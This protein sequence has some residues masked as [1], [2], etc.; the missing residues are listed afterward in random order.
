MKKLRFPDQSASFLHFFTSLGRLQIFL[1]PLSSR[2]RSSP[3]GIGQ[4]LL[5]SLIILL[6]SNVIFSALFYSQQKEQPDAEINHDPCYQKEE[7]VQ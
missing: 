2:L 3:R 4:N 1:I 7:D 6:D 5:H